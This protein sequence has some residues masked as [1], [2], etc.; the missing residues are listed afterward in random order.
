[1]YKTQDLSSSQF[2]K[3]RFVFLKTSNVR[4]CFIG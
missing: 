1:M 3:V 4:T 2:V